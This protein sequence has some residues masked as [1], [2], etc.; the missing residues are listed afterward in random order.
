MPKIVRGS[1]VVTPS[2]SSKKPEDSPLVTIALFCGVGLL[3]SLV[4]IMAGTLDAWYWRRY[5]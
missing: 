5:E 2:A 4:A 1:P 3:V